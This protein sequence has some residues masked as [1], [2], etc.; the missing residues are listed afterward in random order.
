[1][2][3]KTSLDIVPGASWVLVA[4]MG[5][6]GSGK[7]TFIQTASQSPEV[8]VGHDLESC[9]YRIVGRKDPSNASRRCPWTR[10]ELT[11]RDGR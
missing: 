8:V 5:L 1:M 3:F 7:I 4:V 6:T 11:R 10:S 9:M 2:T